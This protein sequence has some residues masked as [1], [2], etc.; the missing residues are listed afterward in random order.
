MREAH[1]TTRYDCIS[2]ENTGKESKLS[3]TGPGLSCSEPGMEGMGAVTGDTLTSPCA[4][5]FSPR[6]ILVLLVDITR[7]SS[8]IHLSIFT[9]EGPP[10]ISETGWTFPK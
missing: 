2:K 3:W 6:D 1:L 7:L 4:G 5:S 10:K 8:R 9:A